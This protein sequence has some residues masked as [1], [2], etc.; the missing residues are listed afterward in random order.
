M[1][2][3]FLRKLPKQVKI[4]EVGPR[5][6]LQNEKIIVSLDDKATY[7]NKLSQAGLKEIEATSFVRAE[8]IPQMSDGLELFK[9]LTAASTLNSK[10]F[11]A[12]VP[13]LKGME[14]AL[15][16]G[17][18]NIAIFTGTSNTFNQKNIN[19]TTSESLKK[20]EEV[21]KLALK[22]N[23]RVRGYISTVFGCPYEGK[24]SLS[25][26]KNIALAFKNMGVYEI[27]LGDTIGVANPRQVVDVIN[28]LSNDFN[29]DFL[30]MHFHDTRGMAL[31]NVLASL[32]C[33]IT[34]F[35]SSSA[36]LGG[37]PYAPGASG[38]VATEDLYY[39]FDSLGIETGIDIKKLID[40]STFIL[41][42]LNKSS[43]SKYYNAFVSSGK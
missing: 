9:N 35:D 20:L 23:I 21:A 13:N 6:G 17:V 26:L 18:Q 34:I 36:G 5:D 27:S 1:L 39:L 19:S 25:E 31:A 22:N 32:E 15:A 33:G 38:N 10:A 8:K 37:C 4:V 40:A 7:I 41:S 12:L 30:A 29:I 28:F 2:D 24:T 3:N 43:P 14:M 11:L 42:K 16:A